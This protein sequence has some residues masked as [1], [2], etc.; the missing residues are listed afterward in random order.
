[1][2]GTHP[3]STVVDL[4]REQARESAV[5]MRFIAD[6]C[7][8]ISFSFNLDFRHCTNKNH[9]PDNLRSGEC[10]GLYLIGQHYGVVLV[11]VEVA[12]V[13]V[14]PVSVPGFVAVV[15]DVVAAVEVSVPGV[16]APV[17]VVVEVVSVLPPQA[18]NAATIAKLAA[19]RLM[20]FMF[21]VIK[22]NRLLLACKCSENTA[23][24]V[25][26]KLVTFANLERPQLYLELILSQTTWNACLTVALFVRCKIHMVLGG[27]AARL[28]VFTDGF[29]LCLRMY[30]RCSNDI[31]VICAGLS[32]PIISKIVGATSA[33]VPL[34][35]FVPFRKLRLSTS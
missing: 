21:N 18:A 26:G 28:L 31:P 1:M 32:S 16:L 2:N 3:G 11:D 7:K 4:F 22:L 24:R 34:D 12:V 25:C 6:F 5:S 13:V 17:D 9:S 8:F 14:V 10:F 20:V 15:V 35:N 23:S 29:K 33:R 27:I 19:A 30:Q